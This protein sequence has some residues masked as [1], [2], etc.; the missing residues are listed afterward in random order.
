LISRKEGV[1]IVFLPFESNATRKEVAS[2]NKQKKASFNLFI[3]F[4]F[5]CHKGAL[6]IAASFTR[7]S[8]A[9]VWVQ[10]SADD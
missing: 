1:F 8:G 7:H 10:N 4:N 2:L 3:Y 6:I 5:G 9:K